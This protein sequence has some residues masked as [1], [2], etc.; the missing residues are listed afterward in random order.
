[1]RALKP[2]WDAVGE[3]LAVSVVEFRTL[4][5]SELPPLEMLEDQFTLQLQIYDQLAEL[6]QIA[7][8]I[9]TEIGELVRNSEYENR[10]TEKKDGEREN[11]G[12]GVEADNDADNGKEKDGEAGENKTDGEADGEVVE[13]MPE[14]IQVL[15]AMQSVVL[16]GCRVTAENAEFTDAEK[17]VEVEFFA[18]QERK[19]VQ[20]AE[21]LGFGKRENTSFSNLLAQMYQVMFLLDKQDLGKL[22]FSIQ[23]EI[24]YGLRA[25]LQ[26]EEVPKDAET[27]KSGNS[28]EKKTE[29]EENLSENTD[30]QAVR[31]TR[32]EGM[33]E[34][35]EEET[36]KTEAER[37]RTDSENET[38]KEENLESTRDSERRS[39]DEL[40]RLQR[41]FWGELPKRE[42]ERL[43]LRPEEKPIPE[44]RKML[45]IYYRKL[46]EN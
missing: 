6:A 4:A 21:S 24:L 27:E 13:I 45:E 33:E 15:I 8:G 31:D 23:E 36:E 10:I 35:T 26:Q 16:E 7:E 3:N 14:D 19:I 28:A 40:K 41:A 9:P 20:S 2:M 25:S 18:G 38:E 43:E 44:Y 22:T 42:L 46:N 29:T 37:M 17:A 32:E 34:E 11:R 12:D 5:E 39:V 30:S 1:P